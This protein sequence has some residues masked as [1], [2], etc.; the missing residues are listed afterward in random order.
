MDHHPIVEC[1]K[2][3]S[4]TLFPLSCSTWWA[5]GCNTRSKVERGNCH[6]G[7]MRVACVLLQ[8]GPAA[9]FKWV[10]YFAMAGWMGEDVK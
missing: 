10:L 5:G 9:A 1:L 8:T 3:L 6:D 2:V 4:A 7:T